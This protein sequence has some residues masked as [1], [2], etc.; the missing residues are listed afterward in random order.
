MSGKASLTGVLIICFAMTSCS[1][2]GEGVKKNGDTI[3]IRGTVRVIGNEP[4][5]RIVLTVQGSEGAKEQQDYLV[6]GSLAK[7]IRDQY[8]GKV[9]VI[10]GK[11]CAESVPE[12]LPCIEPIKIIR[13]EQ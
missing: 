4:F 3:I 2:S 13:S 9:I 11:Y 5:P 8:Q 6:T 1:A 12:R 10:E 7:V